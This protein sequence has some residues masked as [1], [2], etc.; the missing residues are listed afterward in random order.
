MSR[1]IGGH[2]HVAHGLS[3]AMLLPAVTRFSIDS[4]QSRYADCARA[5]RVVPEHLP[6]ALA[7]HALVDELE[8]LCTPWQVPTPHQYGIAEAD[9]N[10]NLD[11]MAGQALAS[12]SPDNNPRIPTAAEIVDLYHEIYPLGRRADLRAPDRGAVAT[13]PVSAA[14]LRSPAQRRIAT[15]PHTGWSPGSVRGADGRS[16]P[17]S[18]RGRDS[19]EHEQCVPAV[20]SECRVLERPAESASVIRVDRC[21]RLRAACSRRP[22]R[23]HA[24]GR[25]ARPGRPLRSCS[26]RSVRRRCAV[27][28]VRS[29]RESAD[30]RPRS[31]AAPTPPGAVHRRRATRQQLATLQL[32]REPARHR[33][34]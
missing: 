17:N 34:P 19:V 18:V 24:G 23:T 8:Q 5:M 1:P 14:D 11:V 7:A 15:G 26:G 32:F 28:T 21:G 25:C 10:D 3:N 33:T 29:A 27:P 9:W 13:A 22:S 6:D 31:A 4:A 30:T 20:G 2:F 12:G 16:W